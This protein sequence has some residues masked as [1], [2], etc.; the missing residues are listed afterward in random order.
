MPPRKAPTFCNPTQQLDYKRFMNESLLALCRAEAE[1]LRKAT[2]KIPVTTNFMAGSCGSVDLWRWARE[3]DVVSNDHY[4]PG[5][6]A[7]HA[8]VIE[9]SLMEEPT[10]STTRWGRRC[11]R[12]GWARSA[13]LRSTTEVPS[14]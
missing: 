12:S 13:S 7:E 14:A 1:I 11:W 10:K 9:T 3:V 4:L 6:E 5:W 8:G 2:P